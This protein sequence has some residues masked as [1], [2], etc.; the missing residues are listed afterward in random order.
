MISQTCRSVEEH[1]VL[2]DFLSSGVKI[3]EGVGAAAWLSRWGLAIVAVAISQLH[4]E[5]LGVLAWLSGWSF[6]VVAVAVAQVHE[7][8]SSFSLSSVSEVHEGLGVFAWLALVV[9]AVV[10]VAVS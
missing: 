10:A 4:E 7:V 1:L 3:L 6:A 2:H 5:G 8:S 9:L